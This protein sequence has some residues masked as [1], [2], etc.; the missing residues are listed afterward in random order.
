MCPDPREVVRNQ[1]PGPA[2]PVRPFPDRRGPEEGGLAGTR[3]NPGALSSQGQCKLTD[4]Y[5][6]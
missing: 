2:Q 3:T 6:R 4:Y 5:L 1:G